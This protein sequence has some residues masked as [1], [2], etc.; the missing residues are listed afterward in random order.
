MWFC[1]WLY[2]VLMV[3]QEVAPGIELNVPVEPFVMDP[4][5]PMMEAAGFEAPQ[6]PGA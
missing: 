5:F 4:G 1:S 6:H 2:H 3:L